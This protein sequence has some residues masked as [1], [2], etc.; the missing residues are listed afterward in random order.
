LRWIG[1]EDEAEIAEHQLILRNVRA[2]DSVIAA[3]RDT[4]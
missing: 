2:T 1:L 4:D 3:A